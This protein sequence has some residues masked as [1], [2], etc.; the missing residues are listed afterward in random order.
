MQWGGGAQS[1]HACEGGRL[2]PCRRSLKTPQRGGTARGRAGGGGWRS[3]G[4]SGD[5]RGADGVERILVEA[6]GQEHLRPREGGAS[7][8]GQ[9]GTAAGQRTALHARTWSMMWMID[10]PQATMSP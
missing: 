3:W 8:D 2:S 7:V 9:P 1:G 6:E 4:G 5:L 10:G